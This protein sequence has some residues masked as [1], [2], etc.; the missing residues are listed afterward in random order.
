LLVRRPKIPREEF[1]S[2]ITV[3]DRRSVNPVLALHCYEQPRDVDQAEL[4]IIVESQKA[5]YYNDQTETA[6]CRIVR[7]WRGWS[8]GPELL[9]QL[10]IED[11]L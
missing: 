2:G 1:L 7:K 3:S 6:V 8:N 9:S 10:K 11:R 4:T 5:R